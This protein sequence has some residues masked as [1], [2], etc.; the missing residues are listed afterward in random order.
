MVKIPP[1]PPPTAPVAAPATSAFGLDAHDESG[2]P[3]NLG[4]IAGANA[5][6]GMPDASTPAGAQAAYTELAKVVPAGHQLIQQNGTEYNLA[7]H[8]ANAGV[9]AEAFTHMSQD[10][11]ALVAHINDAMVK[12]Q[13][14][15]GQ[16]KPGQYEQLKNNFQ[17]L[18]NSAQAQ[19]NAF[20]TDAALAQGRAA[21]AGAP[22]PPVGP[23][24][25]PAPGSPSPSSP[26]VDNAT[27][28][29]QDWSPINKYDHYDPSYDA[30]ITFTT[31][32]GTPGDFA[33]ATSH[34]T[35]AY[36]DNFASQKGPGVDTTR[37]QV[38]SDAWHGG[39]NELERYDPS[40]VKVVPGKGLTLTAVNDPK[41][42]GQYISGKVHAIGPDTGIAQGAVQFTAT[43]PKGGGLWPA[44]WLLPV[45]HNAAAGD[46]P[47]WPGS[48][49]LDVMEIKG[50]DTGTVHG[51]VH[52][53][54]GAFNAALPNNGDMPFGGGFNGGKTDYADGKPHTFGISWDKQGVSWFVDGALYKKQLF[55]DLPPAQAAAAEKAFAGNQKFAPV[56]NLAVG[57]GGF[58]PQY[59]TSIAGPNAAKFPA[60]M[61]VSDVHAWKVPGSA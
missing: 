24:P 32:A 18:L 2:R 17:K 25:A 43:I 26:I 61:T 49:E 10:A 9:A 44:C 5:A 60:T 6:A 1:S 27:Q 45:G 31:K 21:A 50:G 33:A 11:G 19:T 28:P 36:Q 56:I 4:R 53:G 40:Q 14:I 12:L 39:N 46:D 52:V 22:P 20:N 37:W 13:A 7:S 41:A 42:P 23:T 59:A 58:D 16:L 3:W 34:L 29:G 54:Q 8:D 57:G 55:K 30:Q 38:G 48:G 15:S 35:S 51:T 47:S